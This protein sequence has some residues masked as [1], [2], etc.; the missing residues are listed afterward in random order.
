MRNNELELERKLLEGDFQKEMTMLKEQL[1]DSE[2]R[3]DDALYKL[4]SLGQ[5]SNS[6]IQ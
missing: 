3:K 4:K 2:T 5:Q 6:Q 1:A